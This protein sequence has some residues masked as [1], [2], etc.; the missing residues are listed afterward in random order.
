MIVALKPLVWFSQ[1][2][3][4]LI[5][6]G[7]AQHPPRH[8]E[9]LMAVAHLG[10]ESGQLHARESQ[11]L[12]NMLQLDQVKT[13]DIMTPRTVTFLL[14]AATTS[15]EFIRQVDGKPFTRI[16][17]WGAHADD[18]QGFVI[19][20]EVLMEHVKRVAAEFTLNEVARP[21]QSTHGAL[22][23]DRLF[24]RF[25][26]EHHQIMLVVDEY[27]SVAGI[28]TLEDVLETIFGFEIVD[29]L[30]KVPDLQA[31]ARDLWKAR[32]GRLGIDA[33]EALN[34]SGN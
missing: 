15:D 3:T 30:D 19:K 26:S 6:F 23:V 29:E 4:R 12:H 24:Q 8:R 2:L 27:G 11:F 17:V 14:P 34:S 31:Y 32:A 1:Q 21:I 5:T 13:F 20:G 25:V 9:E 33:E 7:K 28:V 18:I 22:T 16:P 10:H